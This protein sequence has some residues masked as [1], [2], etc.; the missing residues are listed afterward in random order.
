MKSVIVYYWLTEAWVQGKGPASMALDKIASGGQTGVDRGALDAALAVGFACGGWCPKERNAED[1]PIP[2]SYPMT[3]PIGSG[4]RQRMVKNVVDS[5]GTAILFNQTLSGGTLYTH[6]VCR[7]ERKP[8][9]VARSIGGCLAPFTR[10]ERKFAKNWRGTGNRNYG[11]GRIGE[12]PG[13]A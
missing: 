10:G 12:C 5:D 1:G 8:F 2:G 9:I 7:R 3:L 11:N 6:D 13:V 4:Y